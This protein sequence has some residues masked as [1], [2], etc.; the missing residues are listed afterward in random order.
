MLKD[1][2]I[3]SLDQAV[4]AAVAA[5]ALAIENVP[6]AGVERPRDPSHGDYATNIAMVLAKAARKN[7]LEI[8]KAIAAHVPAGSALSAVDVAPPGFINMRLSAAWL[9][10]NL[11]TILKDGAAYG[12]GAKKPG[13]TLLEFVSANPTGPLHVGHGRWAALGSALANL[14]R[15]AGHE[16]ATEFYIN[17][18]GNQMQLLGRS[19]EARMRQQ[20]GEDVQV[21]EEGYMGTYMVDVAAKALAELPGALDLPEAE[22]VAKL[23]DYARGELLAQQQATL[24]EL[25]TH[26]DVYFSELQLHPAGVTEA[27]EHLKG[28]GHLYEKDG[29][30]WLRSTD[31]GDDKDRVV[32]R[33]NG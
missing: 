22:R 31:F 28:T 17:D 33:D 14:L 6:P 7:P 2:L 30:W 27:I 12:H 29:A 23:T 15:V 19:L 32:V 18:A 21:P 24:A 13:K 8:A 5:G 25:R 16:V 26:F 11:A 9:T 20:R 10:Q 4:A 3:A 1:T